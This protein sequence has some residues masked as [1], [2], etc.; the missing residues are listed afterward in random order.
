[1]KRHIDTF[2]T[3]DIEF[4]NELFEKDL[5]LLDQIFSKLSFI[6][7]CSHIKIDVDDKFSGIENLIVDKK[8]HE[9]VRYYRVMLICILENNSEKAKKIL[10]DLDS[11]KIEKV[12]LLE[13]YKELVGPFSLT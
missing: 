8:F 9:L 5:I 3:I 11:D 10:L 2:F 1:M 13:Y 7:I 12:E 6:L 4:F